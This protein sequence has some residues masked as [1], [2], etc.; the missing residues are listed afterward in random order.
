M[1]PETIIALE[2]LKFAIQQDLATIQVS[3]A[4]PF[5]EL[6]AAEDIII[7]K[8]LENILAKVEPIH[9]VTADAEMIAD[10]L[11]RR[12]RA[13]K[14]IESHRLTLHL[15]T[16]ARQLHEAATTHCHL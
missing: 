13:Y 6:T 14:A 3:D 11:R 15:K 16:R 2:R 4:S 7:V 10:Y 5:Q 12:A 1:K 8:S 9:V